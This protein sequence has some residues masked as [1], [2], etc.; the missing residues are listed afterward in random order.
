MAS[1]AAEY[2]RL[3]AVGAELTRRERK[4]GWFE[5]VEHS[6]KANDRRTANTTETRK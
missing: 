5:S 6:R 2:Q 3:D 4:I 1:H